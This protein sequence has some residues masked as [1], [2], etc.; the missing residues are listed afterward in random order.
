LGEEN[1][2]DG[3]DKAPNKKM[4]DFGTYDGSECNL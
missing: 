3:Q 1:E 2:M 4:V